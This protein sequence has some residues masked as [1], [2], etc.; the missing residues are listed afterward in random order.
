M[1]KFSRENRSKLWTSLKPF[2]VEGK[3]GQNNWVQK[4]NHK[5]QKRINQKKIVFVFQTPLRGETHC[6]QYILPPFVLDM[7]KYRESAVDTGV[8]H[9]HAVSCKPE[10]KCGFG[11]H[12]PAVPRTGGIFHPHRLNPGRG[13]TSNTSSVMTRCSGGVKT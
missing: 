5:K 8:H 3:K 2:P 11:V 12:G 4:Q 1:S 6:A 9:G 7:P 13:S 10:R